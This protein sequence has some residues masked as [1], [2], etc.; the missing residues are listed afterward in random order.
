MTFTSPSLIHTSSSTATDLHAHHRREALALHRVRRRA[1][2]RRRLTTLLATIRGT[3]A[4]FRVQ[5]RDVEPSAAGSG[6]RVDL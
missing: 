2:R 4:P 1:R 6:G 5:W 3:A